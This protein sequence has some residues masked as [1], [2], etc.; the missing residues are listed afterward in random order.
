MFSCSV[1]L[2]PLD[3]ARL[4][5]PR[6]D[7]VLGPVAPTRRVLLAPAHTG[8]SGVFARTYPRQPQ[9]D[10]LAQG[11]LVEQVLRAAAIRGALLG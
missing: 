5:A 8:R 6:L 1:R 11:P 7:V 2:L 9:H 4:D 10:P 3:D